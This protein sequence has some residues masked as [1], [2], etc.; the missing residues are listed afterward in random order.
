MLTAGTLIVLQP[1]GSLLKSAAGCGLAGQ[2]I[3][4]LPGSFRTGAVDWQSAVAV[5]QK[6]RVN[7]ESR[8]VNPP[9]FGKRQC[10]VD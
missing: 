10:P 3:P 8:I 4:R 1:E 9:P 5:V 6:N 7:T 2:V